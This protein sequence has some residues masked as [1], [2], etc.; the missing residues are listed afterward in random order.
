MNIGN[1]TSSWDDDTKILEIYL[2]GETIAQIS[3]SDFRTAFQIS[4]VISKIRRASFQ[5]GEASISSK[6]TEAMNRL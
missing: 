2:D 5:A 6:I 3:L 4:E 1:S